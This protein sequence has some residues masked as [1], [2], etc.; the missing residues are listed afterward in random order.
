MRLTQITI[1]LHALRLT[2]IVLCLVL[3]ISTSVASADDIVF[4]RLFGPEVPSG[5]YKH[6]AAIE[7]LGTTRSF[8]VHASDGQ[9]EVSLEGTTS[10]IEVAKDQTQATHTWSASDFGLLPVGKE[11]L[12][13]T[14]PVESAAIIRRIFEGEPGPCRDTV[15][16]GT[17]A[18]LLLVGQV[19][20]VK[21]GVR[22]AA[23]AVDGGAA[24]GKLDELRS[25]R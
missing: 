22:Q 1:H 9:D 16:A 23:E 2:Q 25:E 18:A 3:A 11:A 15:L 24:S 6:P 13:A 7:Q 20:S 19:D 17:A 12:A 21:E 10:A 5:I 4:E 14:D 8:I